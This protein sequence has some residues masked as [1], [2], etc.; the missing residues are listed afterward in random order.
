[1]LI[2]D[3]LDIALAVPGC[4]LH[5]GQSDLPATLV[6][7]L[8]GDKAIIGVSTNEASDIHAVIEEG[9]A[10]YIGIGPVHFTASKDVLSPILGPRGISRM[11]TVLGHSK[12][13]AVAIGGVSQKTIDNLMRQ[14]PGLLDDGSYRELDGVAIVSALA[15]SVTPKET[16]IE[17]LDLFNKG[18]GRLA[19]QQHIATASQ[20]TQGSVLGAVGSIIN[21]LKARPSALIHHITNNVVQNDTANLTLCFGC[22]PIM[23]GSAQ[24]AEEL[25]RK[26]STLLINFGTINTDQIAVMVVAG[27]TAVRNS[28]PVLFDPVGIGAT[29]F[30]LQGAESSS[31]FIIPSS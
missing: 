25:G 31:L 26:I 19:F 10:D 28:K 8:L 24:E 17:L 5:V 1:M 29:D 11:L 15:A 23:S 7:K 6:R 13:K 27:Q 2:N 4:G 16:A 30:R 21:L 22:S 3:R 12:V 18:P 9:V 20:F 14:S